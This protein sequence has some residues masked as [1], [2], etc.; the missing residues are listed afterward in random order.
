MMITLCVLKKPNGKKKKKLQRKKTIILS[1]RNIGYGSNMRKNGVFGMYVNLVYN[2][3]M[4]RSKNRPK[5]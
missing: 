1:F 5:I 4:H 2:F 3:W